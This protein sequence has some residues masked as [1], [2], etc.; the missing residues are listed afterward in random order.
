LSDIGGAGPRAVR[1]EAAL[2]ELADG[3]VGDVGRV[4]RDRLRVELGDV[5]RPHEGLRRD[6]VEAHVEAHHHRVH[7]AARRIP[8]GART[9]PSPRPGRGIDARI[10][11]VG[12]QPRVDH[13]IGAIGLDRVHRRDAVRD[14]GVVDVALAD[15][16]LDTGGAKPRDDRLVKHLAL[17]RGRAHR[18]DDDLA[19]RMLRGAQ[20][21]ADAGVRRQR[22][23][24]RGERRCGER[25]EERAPPHPFAGGTIAC[26]AS[27][28]STTSQNPGAS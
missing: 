25:R 16:A 26:C 21:A 9:H 24:A 19:I 18:D 7:G 28:P 11:I 27:A 13:A 23:A 4:D 17:V 8:G 20:A 1:D 12:P 5:T 2:D 10:G 3:R 6:V 15:D 14:R 22:R